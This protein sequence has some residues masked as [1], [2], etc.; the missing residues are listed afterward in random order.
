MSFDLYNKL[1]TYQHYMNDVFFDY[2]DDFVF[3][4]IDD[5][6]IYNNF[7]KEHIKHVKKV[8]RRLR[9]ANLQANIDKYEFS[10]HEI[11]YLDL[12]VRRNEIK[13]NSKKIEIILQW[14]TSQSLKQIQKFLK[15]CNFYKRFI[16]NF[17]KIVKS[18][19]KIT[20]KNVSFVWSDAC[21]RTFE[22]LKRIIMKT[23]ILT[24]FDLK[25]QTYIKSDSSNFV[26]VN[27]LFQMKKNDELHSVTFFSKNLVSTEC[28]Y[29]I[30]DKKLLTILRCFKQWRSEL[31]FIK[32]NVLI[33]VLTNHKNLKY[34]MFTKQLN[35]RQSRWAQFLIDFHFIIVTI[36]CHHIFLMIIS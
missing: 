4:Y 17:A 15:F 10:V 3:V 1:V 11:K 16:K 26:N 21:R 8:L 24:H 20:R 32:S 22:L 28:N 6:F 2:L 9:D 33:K 35:R 13:I 36:V 7:K 19:I 27:V 29:E 14:A 25:K 30:Y 23:S 12:T 18:L 5:I 34:F 31:L